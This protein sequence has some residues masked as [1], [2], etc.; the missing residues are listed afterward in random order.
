[1]T[2]GSVIPTAEAVSA[3]PAPEKLTAVTA[4]AFANVTV[5]VSVGRVPAATVNP[6]SVN[7]AP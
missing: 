5:P 3:G 1:M 6:L 7:T 2:E 4:S